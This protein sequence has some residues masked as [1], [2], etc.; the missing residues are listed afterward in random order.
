M[1]SGERAVPV[2]GGGLSLPEEL[3]DVPVEPD[4][5]ELS[6]GHVFCAADLAAAGRSATETVEGL[7]HIPFGGRVEELAVVLG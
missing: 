4:A 5:L 1:R 2:T 7:G 6:V 3:V